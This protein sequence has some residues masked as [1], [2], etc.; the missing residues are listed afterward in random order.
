MPELVV[1]FVG[2][3]QPKLAGL[4]AEGRV[5]TV[6]RS[7]LTIPASAVV[8]D[9]DAAYAWRV[10]DGKLTKAPIKLADRD[11]RSGDFAIVQGL[12]AGDQV[13]RY[14]TSL[15]RDNQPIQSGQSPSAPKAAM[16]TPSTPAAATN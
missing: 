11:P 15:L 10:G 12:A 2:E 8:R 14:P 13:I 5:D 4:Y 3:K 1:D 9:G 7:G 6:V 16:A